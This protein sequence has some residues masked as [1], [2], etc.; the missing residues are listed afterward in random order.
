MNQLAEQQV[1]VLRIIRT[2]R[3]FQTKALARLIRIVFG[4][5][6]RA[7][8]ETISIHARGHTPQARIGISC[9]AI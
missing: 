8:T 4:T 1:A 6:H 2:A 9:R 3:A 5:A 7:I